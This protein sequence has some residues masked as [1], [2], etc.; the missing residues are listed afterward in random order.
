MAGQVVCPF[1][2]P[3]T[4]SNE[5]RL[6]ESVA[7]SVPMGVHTCG[8]CGAVASASHCEGWGELSR[9]ELEKLVRN[10]VSGA[11]PEKCDVVEAE[12]KGEGMPPRLLWAKKAAPRPGG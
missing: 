7:P 9:A 6:V 2:P 12:V 8:S 4:P 10:Y 3:G 11:S 1:C 5:L